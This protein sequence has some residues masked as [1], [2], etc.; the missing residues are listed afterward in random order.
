MGKNLVAP[1]VVVLPTLPSG[2]DL[3]MIRTEVTFKDYNFFAKN[4]GRVIPNDNGWRLD[5]RPVVNVS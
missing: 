1:T 2:K 4:T 5:N 3:A